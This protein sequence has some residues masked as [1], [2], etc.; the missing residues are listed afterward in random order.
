MRPLQFHWPS[1]L[2]K[3]KRWWWWWCCVCYCCLFIF[4]TVPKQSLCRIGRVKNGDQ[5]L[6][7]ESKACGCS[8]EEAGTE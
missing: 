1:S 8:K 4:I 6:C 3:I 2:S 5:D 7:R